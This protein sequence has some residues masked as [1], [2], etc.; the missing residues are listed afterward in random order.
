MLYQRKSQPSKVISKSSKP[1]WK[2]SLE[3]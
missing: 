1:S 2:A 3:F